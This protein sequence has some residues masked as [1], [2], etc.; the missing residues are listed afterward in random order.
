MRPALYRLATRLGGLFF[1]LLVV[2]L[3]TFA[4][5]HLL[6]GDPARLM[7]GPRASDAAVEALRSQYGLDRPLPLQYLLYLKA[8]VQGDL[9]RSIVTQ[10]PVL[11]ELLQVLPATLELVLVALML[12]VLAGGVLGVA[13][14]VWRGGV[15]DVLTRLAAGVVVA[16][17]SFWLALVLLLLFYGQLGWLPGDGRL[18]AALDPPPPLTGLFLVDALLA[19]QWLQLGDALRH[20]LLPALTLAIPTAAG[21]L[22]MLRSAMIEVLNEDYIRTALACGI[23]RRDIIVRHALR[24]ALNPV[25]TA[26][27]LEFSTLVFGAVVVE[28]VFSWPGA[29][30]Y[31]VGAIFALDLPVIMGFTVLAALITVAVNGLVELGYRLANPQLRETRR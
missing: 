7:A 17:P 18:S 14:A 23:R 9:G 15:F 6:P 1:V 21:V 11:G 26:V 27:G 2:T 4:L 5:T 16:A 31:V 10:Q 25:I 24:N 12:G 8:L 13:A 30:A 19:G 20:L 3:V 28:T 29:G 22:R